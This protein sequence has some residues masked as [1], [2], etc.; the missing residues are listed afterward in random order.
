MRRD[1]HYSENID[2]LGRAVTG[3]DSDRAEALRRARARWRAAEDRLFPV[4]LVD[5][6]GYRRLLSVVAVLLEKLRASTTSLDQLLELDSHPAPLVAA[7]AVAAGD[8]AADRMALEAA[9]AVRDRELAAA[10]ER[11][12][13]TRAIAAA[14]NAG[15]RW[16]DL[17]GSWE[18]VCRTG[19]RH[20]EMHLAS[21]RALVATVDPYS[22]DGPHRLEVVVL[23]T[24]T[25]A[26]VETTDQERQ[27]AD[28][29]T[30]AAQREQWR[31][32]IDRG[33]RP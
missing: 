5:P 15:A 3:L 26:P 12:R 24:D 23:D 20:T 11:D 19:L 10:A 6:D 17:E 27:F 25:G 21:G 13:R 29:A 28:R 22:G 8:G 1:V 18:A 14:R 2:D 16:V 30:W 32:Q 4:A 9:F 33:S 7:A 31:M